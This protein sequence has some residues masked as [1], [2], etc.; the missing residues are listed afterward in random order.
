M[1]IPNFKILSFE[2]YLNIKKRFVKR[3]LNYLKETSEKKLIAEG[4]ADKREI[5]DM[6]IFQKKELSRIFAMLKYQKLNLNG[7]IK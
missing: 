4:F 6:I 1:K 2:Q 5:K 3:S 7:R